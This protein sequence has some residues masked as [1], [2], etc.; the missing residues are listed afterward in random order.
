MRGGLAPPEEM[1]TNYPLPS[2]TECHE[3]TIPHQDRQS[4]EIAD[5]GSRN[6]YAQCL[7]A[8]PPPLTVRQF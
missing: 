8:Q 1:G 4:C 5:A 6:L 2:V 7:P 3:E